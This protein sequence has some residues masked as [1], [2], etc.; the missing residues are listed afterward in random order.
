MK[1]RTIDIKMVVFSPSHK[2]HVILRLGK[3]CNKV[4]NLV[5]SRLTSFLTLHFRVM[6]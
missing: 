6:F 2:I 5:L 4:L 1:Y 3:N